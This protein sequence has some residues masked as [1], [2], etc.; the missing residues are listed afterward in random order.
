MR[1]ND[2]VVRSHSLTN[3]IPKTSHGAEI[4]GVVRR[5]PIVLLLG[6]HRSG[7]SLCSH[8]LSMLGVDMADTVMTAPRSDNPRGHWE[9]WEIVEFHDRILSFFNRG[10]FT[11]FHD[12]SLPIAWWADPRVAEVRGQI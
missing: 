2:S 7:T 6:M 10:Y 8:I 4:V 12:L 5:R 9:R 3:Q 11:P 1:M